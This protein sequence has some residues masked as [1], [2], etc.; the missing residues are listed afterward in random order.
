MLSRISSK[1]Q[2]ARRAKSTKNR[3]LNLENLER[4]VVFSG[5]AFA[6]GASALDASA[7]AEVGDEPV[8]G[9]D[10]RTAPLLE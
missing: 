1:N 10:R 9:A 2:T 3:N 8:Y 4:R 6:A 7:S 5:D